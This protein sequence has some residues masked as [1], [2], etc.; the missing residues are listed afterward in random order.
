MQMVDF[1]RF[2]MWSKK[3]RSSL[4][5]FII[6]SSNH[7]YS[8]ESKSVRIAGLGTIFSI[9]LSAK[10]SS[11]SN[12]RSLEHQLIKIIA[13]YEK[14]FSHWSKSSELFS[15]Q[16]K[17]LHKLQCPSNLFLQGLALAVKMFDFSGESFD[18]S[19]K[20]K[21][22]RSLH[23]L[24]W[25]KGGSCFCFKNRGVKLDFGGIVKG[26]CVGELA[27][28]LYSSGVKIFLINAGNGDLA[29]RGKNYLNLDDY[30]PNLVF[31][32]SNSHRY[33]M[34]NNEWKIHIKD[35]VNFTGSLTNSS[36]VICRSS[37]KDLVFWSE[38][39]SYC[40]AMSTSSLNNKK[41]F[42]FKGL[43]KLSKR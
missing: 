18:V 6:L 25:V 9:K 15:L 12:S 19:Y 34:Q 31:F 23:S 38:L 33:Q 1:L 17:G 14:T 24:K 30:S 27:Q 39:G 28:F 37:N 4:I 22:S 21:L 36:Q 11:F 35:Q 10:D 43:C 42:Y 8:Y 3:L 32:V 41:S 13:K 16:K 40:D 20:S 5:F 26:M 29:F 7:I 2:S